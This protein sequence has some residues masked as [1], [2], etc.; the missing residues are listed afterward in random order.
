MGIEA[1]Y[2]IHEEKQGNCIGYYYEDLKTGQ[3]R[4]VWLIQETVFAEVQKMTR[5]QGNPMTIDAP[6]LWRRLLDAGYIIKYATRPN[7]QK[8]T[9][10]QVRVSK[11]QTWVMV[12]SA[13]A[14]ESG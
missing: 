11:V 7:G 13:D 8:Q 3:D 14:I 9:T 2:V 6:T 10:Y 1:Q 5:N 4:Q 12:I